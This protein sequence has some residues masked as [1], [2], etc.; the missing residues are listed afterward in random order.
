MNKYIMER[1]VEE[2]N[3]WCTV[4][5]GGTRDIMAAAGVG[6]DFKV[7]GGNVAE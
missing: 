4:E 5:R 7:C 6:E 3:S 1:K 2:G